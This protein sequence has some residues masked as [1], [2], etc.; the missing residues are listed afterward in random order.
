MFESCTVWSSSGRGGD[1]GDE[2]LFGVVAAVDDEF[3]SL[4]GSGTARCYVVARR[5]DG[6]AAHAVCWPRMVTLG[7]GVRR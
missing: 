7:L 1:D 4:H 3:V 5:S 6:L 2:W